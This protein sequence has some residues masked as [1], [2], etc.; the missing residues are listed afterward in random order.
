MQGDGSHFRGV[1]KVGRV[2][3]KGETSRVEPGLSFHE[4]VGMNTVGQ[5]AKVF[6]NTLWIQAHWVDLKSQKL[7]AASR[8]ARKYLNWSSRL[9]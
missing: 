6:K 7:M 4:V 9:K 8:G 5:E 3:A 2:M 1:S